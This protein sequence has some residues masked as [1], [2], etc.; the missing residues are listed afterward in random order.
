MYSARHANEVLSALG[1]RHFNCRCT[2]IPL[3]TANAVFGK[4]AKGDPVSENSVYKP[5]R[6]G[7]KPI[8]LSFTGRHLLQSLREEIVEY[9]R[10]RTQ[11]ARAGLNGSPLNA[12]QG[13][14]RVRERIAQYMS[15]LERRSSS[16]FL[17]DVPTDQLDKELE[18]RGYY[19]TPQNSD[20]PVDIC[21]ARLHDAGFSVSLYAPHVFG[22]K[23][24]VSGAVDAKTARQISERMASMDYRK[25]QRVNERMQGL[26]NPFIY[27]FRNPDRNPIPP[28]VY[29]VEVELK[30][31][32]E[33]P[34]TEYIAKPKPPHQY[35]RERTILARGAKA[36]RILARR[37]Y[38][39]DGFRD[40]EFD[41]YAKVAD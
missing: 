34:E 1:G 25:R 10:L 19:V 8:P 22:H 27:G 20:V 30:H 7:A 41:L 28:G 4:F 14:S 5:S 24:E 11:E 13:L 35:L 16:F 37:V 32:G 29:A 18:S 36:A 2:T 39:K 33:I 21:L 31:M 23:I 3:I 38:E 15:E 9:T 12:W 40:F 26:R 17:K 6:E